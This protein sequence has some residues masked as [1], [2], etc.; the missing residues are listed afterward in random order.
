MLSTLICLVSL[1]NAKRIHKDSSQPPRGSVQVARNAMKGMPRQFGP[2]GA[3][4]RPVAAIQSKQYHTSHNLWSTWNR[5]GPAELSRTLPSRQLHSDQVAESIWP[6]EGF[7]AG[8]IVRHIISDEAC[9]IVR[10]Y[11]NQGQKGLECRSKL[12]NGLRWFQ[13]E[14]VLQQLRK[15]YMQHHDGTRRNSGK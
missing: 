12:D 8:Q 15:V 4:A 14:D 7:E 3:R 10:F 13:P 9:V 2:L 1:G 5:G 6:P 11:N